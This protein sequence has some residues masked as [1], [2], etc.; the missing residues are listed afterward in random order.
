MTNASPIG[1]FR[2]EADMDRQARL[3]KSVESDP[4][5]T[6]ALEAGMQIA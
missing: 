2:T 6:S 4:E 5:Q 3:A 1:C